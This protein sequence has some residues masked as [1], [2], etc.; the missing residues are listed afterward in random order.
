MDPMDPSSPAPNTSPPAPAAASPPTKESLQAEVGG[1][2]D[3][4]KDDIKFPIVTP[5]R[6][7]KVAQRAANLD[8][9][10]AL[11]AAE[12]AATPEPPSPTTSARPGRVALLP[13]IAGSPRAARRPPCRARCRATP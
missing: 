1:L 3:E 11:E 10:A 7:A 5:Q 6:T 9:L 8:Q 13:F 2:G 12:A 4:L